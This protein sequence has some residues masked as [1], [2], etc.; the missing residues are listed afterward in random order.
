MRRLGTLVWEATASSTLNT[1]TGQSQWI[2][3]LRYLLAFSATGFAQLQ[4]TRMSQ[5]TQSAV[6]FLR[7]LS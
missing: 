5:G 3:V 2:F 7:H 1:H 6:F 4:A